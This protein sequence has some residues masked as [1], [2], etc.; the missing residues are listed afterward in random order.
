MKIKAIHPLQWIAKSIEGI[1][2]RFPMNELYF[3][4]ARPEDSRELSDLVN[5][6]YR[7]EASKAGWTTE[8]DLLGGP[9]TTPDAILKYLSDPT[10]RIRYL[11]E[12]SSDPTQ[13][14]GPILACV[15][16]QKVLATHVSGRTDCH[17]TML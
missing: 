13:K 9:R 16:I 7:G 12:K 5:S 10:I 3:S 8:A 2:H 11:Y 6:A 4:D 15:K 14:Q 1:L 17:L